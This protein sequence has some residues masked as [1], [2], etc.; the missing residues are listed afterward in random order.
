MPKKSGGV[1]DNRTVL[2]QILSLSCQNSPEITTN[3]SKIYFFSP[4][5]FIISDFF[6][7]L[8]GNF[9][10]K[11]IFRFFSFAYRYFLVFELF[12]KM[13]R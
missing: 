13:S 8:P 2:I 10:N 3:Y 12:A 1:I 4:E 6:S 11:W 7:S 9:G 5:Y